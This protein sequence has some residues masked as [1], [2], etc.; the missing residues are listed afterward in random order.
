M[1]TW[2]KMI[3]YLRIENL[4]N[5]TLSRGTYLY[6]PY[7]GVPPP[8]PGDAGRRGGLLVS[9]VWVQALAGDSVLCSR[10]RHLT[11]TVPEA[12]SAQVYKWVPEYSM[13]GVTLRWTSIP[14]R[15]E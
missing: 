2:A 5:P 3:P 14:S 15:G 1:P 10:A 6:S 9:A 12:L 8:P 13:L 4:K 7:M 11:V